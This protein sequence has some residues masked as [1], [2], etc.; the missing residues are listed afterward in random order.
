[1]E[2]NKIIVHGVYQHWKNPEH[3]YRILGFALD[4]NTL[5]KRVIYR[6]L[7]EGDYPK[8]TR[9]D[10]IE[11]EFLEKIV[12]NG[13]EIPKFKYIGKEMPGS[14]NGIKKR[15]HNLKKKSD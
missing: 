4:R 8:G 2:D 10:G 7:Y 13:K 15:R 9:W 5:E 12:V 6:Q 3:Y 1:M 11:R 14:G